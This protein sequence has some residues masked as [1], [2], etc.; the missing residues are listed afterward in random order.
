MSKVLNFVNIEG[1][2]SHD[3]ITLAINTAYANAAAAETAFF[4]H[5]IDIS[6]I[7]PLM[8]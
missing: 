5:D 8:D 2:V 6:V 4:Q 1:G 7:V 3:V